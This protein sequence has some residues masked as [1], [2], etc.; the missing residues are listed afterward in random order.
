MKASALFGAGWEDDS[1]LDLA[2]VIKVSDAVCG[3][4]VLEKLIDTLMRADWD[5]DP[6][7]SVAFFRMIVTRLYEGR[8]IEREMRNRVGVVRFL[9][10]QVSGADE[11]FRD[12]ARC[13][14]APRS[15]HE[16]SSGGHLRDRSTPDCPLLPN[17]W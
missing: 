10:N 4:I 15:E 16:L 1:H 11:A 17:A 13:V 12:S 3:E 7:N 14:P 2:T 9:A 5:K 8:P 6:N